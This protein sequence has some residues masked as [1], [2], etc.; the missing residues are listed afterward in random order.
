MCNCIKNLEKKMIGREVG[1]GT[2][3]R[4]VEKATFISGAIVFGKSPAFRTSSVLECTL[5]G[6]KKPYEQNVIH[7]F[8]PFCGEEYPD[9]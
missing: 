4:K 1:N 5:E 2:K 7:A 8:C 6:Q 9:N 3:K